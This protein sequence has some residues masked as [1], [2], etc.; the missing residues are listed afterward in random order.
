MR[1]FCL[2]IAPETTNDGFGGNASAQTQ[3]FDLDS[4]PPQRAICGNQE[5]RAK[6]LARD[7]NIMHRP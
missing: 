2:E 3:K 1:I 7:G 6:H 5:R 4:H